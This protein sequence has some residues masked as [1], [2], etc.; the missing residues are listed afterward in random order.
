MGKESQLSKIRDTPT[1]H[2][3][4]NS[5]ERNSAGDNTPKKRYEVQKE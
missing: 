1:S 2:Y 4:S 5:I 3:D